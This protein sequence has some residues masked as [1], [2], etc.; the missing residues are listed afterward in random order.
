MADAVAHLRRMGEQVTDAL[1]A[2]SSPV[3]WEHVGLS[4]DFLWDRASAL[5]S[6]R[7]PLNLPGRRQAA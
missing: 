1:L 3:D 2:H 4:G 7:R 5:P 6:G